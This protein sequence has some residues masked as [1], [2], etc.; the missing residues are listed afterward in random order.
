VEADQGHHPIRESRLEVNGSHVAGGGVGAILGV[1]L[2]GLGKKVGLE[3]TDAD[4]A[5]LGVACA[6]IG[7][8]VGHAL[9]KAWAGP[10]VFPAI[11][12]GL[13]GRR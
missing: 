4:A 5:T 11:R 13:F 8:A 10:G 12:R 6:G 9:G 7:I 1:A 3:L 2:A